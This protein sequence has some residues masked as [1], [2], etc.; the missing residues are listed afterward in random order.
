VK[1]ALNTTVALSLILMCLLAGLPLANAEETDFTT[2]E[3]LIELRTGFTAPPQPTSPEETPVSRRNKNTVRQQ[4]PPEGNIELRP[5]KSARKKPA[6]QSA[7]SAV[8]GPPAVNTVTEE[9]PAPSA[10]KSWM[11]TLEEAGST[12]PQATEPEPEVVELED[13][14]DNKYQLS[15]PVEA[16]ETPSP[17][18][19]HIIND[20][21]LEKEDLANLST[22][23]KTIID[24]NPVIQYGL[25]QLATPPE[26]RYAHSSIMTRTVGG[27][28]SGASLVPY[29]MGADQLTAGATMLSTQ[30]VDRAMQQSQRIDPSD[31][32]S[33]TELVE[34]SGIVQS[35][36]KKLVENYFQYKSSLVTYVQLG[37]LMDR[38][39]RQYHRAVDSNNTLE[40]LSIRHMYQNTRHQ[41]FVA[42][43]TAK[44]HYLVLERMVGTQGMQ[45]LRFDH[46]RIPGMDK[47]SPDLSR[48]TS[49]LEKKDMPL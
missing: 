19:G 30:L 4:P 3:D 28:L 41:Q 35:L 37:H 46:A 22:L 10:E 39:K 2:V 24:R 23:W 36:Q 29:M 33:D 44:R 27:L 18:K 25:K 5:G 8:Q 17:L 14:P 42:R 40:Q 21:Q 43:E 13:K 9:S 1:L 48:E 6:R 49:A 7:P 26:L 47:A 11:E 34:L 38:L 31:L 20:S 45:Q 16:M 15:R 32:P 12:P